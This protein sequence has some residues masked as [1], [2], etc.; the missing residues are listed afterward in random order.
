VDALQAPLDR[1]LRR[2]LDHA[3][4]EG[5]HAAALDPN[6][7]EAQIRGTWVNPHHNLHEE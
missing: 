2:G 5:D 3:T 1:Q 6:Y 4:V 7:A